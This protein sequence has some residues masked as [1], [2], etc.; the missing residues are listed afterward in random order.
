MT[1]RDIRDDVLRRVWI[2][3]PADAVPDFVLADVATAINQALQTL[4]TLP[5]EDWFRRQEIEVSL[6][7]GTNRYAL[8]S[9][10]QNVLGVTR[11]NGS[12]LRP[13]Q[14]RSD[15][16]NY[17]KRFT[18]ATTEANGT[19]AAF[20]IE[21]LASG[22]SSDSAAAY[23]WLAPTPS[24]TATLTMEVSSE[25]PNY[26]VAQ[27][28][29]AVNTIPMPHAYVESLLLPVARFFATRC[30]WFNGDPGG[31]KTDAEAAFA[32]IGATAPWANPEK[33]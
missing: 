13:V 10:I 1:R 31:L 4:W 9:T 11:A 20:W 18:G 15:I 23:L 25:A 8:P 22:G 14:S 2:E 28:D 19:P 5:R 26:T 30:H 27:L 7:A 21:R 29:D 33:P 17:A 12:E 6:V 24:A 3:R 32:R 16:D